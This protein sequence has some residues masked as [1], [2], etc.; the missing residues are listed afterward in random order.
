M[1]QSLILID[2]AELTSIVAEAVHGVTIGKTRDARALTSAQ[3]QEAVSISE[4]TVKNLRRRGLPH[5]FIGDSPRFS[6]DEVLAWLRV[7]GA[8][9][10]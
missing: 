2:R 1:A 4:G 7:H 8:E 10:T 3:L 5:Y 6:L 9:R